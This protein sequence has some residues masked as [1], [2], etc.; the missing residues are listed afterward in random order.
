MPFLYNTVTLELHYS[1]FDPI[2]AAF[3]RHRELPQ[4]VAE[5]VRTA[6]GSITRLSPATRI[7]DLGAGTGRFG[8]VFVAA[9]DLYVGVDSSQ[10]MLRA[11]LKHNAD[12][13][14]ILA[15]GQ[16]LP[17]RDGTFGIVMLMQVL[18]GLRDWRG[19]L[20]EARRVLHPEGAI[21]V[22]HT[23]SPPQGIN[24]Q[25]KEH[26]AIILQEMKAPWHEPKKS[27]GQALAWLE[28]FASRH[29]RIR[30]AEWKAHLTPREFLDRRRTGARFAAL[31]AA[32]QEEALQELT[33]W[34]QSTFGSL[35][36]I[37]TEEH[38]FELDIFHHSK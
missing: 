6:I 1:T 25:L 2:A 14:L 26:L 12:A 35:D 21:V 20:S 16:Q 8:K 27:R 18:S 9:N 28:T 31:P 38:S 29:E 15:D 30:V 32:V 3:D 24:T 5:A 33:A 17:F 36:T 34:A 37:F 23:V 22:G 10:E 13:C 11:F 7:L 4:G 19:L